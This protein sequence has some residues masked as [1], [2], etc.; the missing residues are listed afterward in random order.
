M[1]GIQAHDRR[2]NET[3]A[4]PVVRLAWTVHA[5]IVVVAVAAILRIIIIIDGK[6]IVTTN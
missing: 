6:G 5:T 4:Q 2:D 1:S 3:Q